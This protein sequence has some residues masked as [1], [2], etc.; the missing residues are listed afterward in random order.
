MHMI[1]EQVR[2]VVARAPAYFFRGER[3]WQ[4]EA[5]DAAW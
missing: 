3:L 4:S 2:P 5:M 1:Q